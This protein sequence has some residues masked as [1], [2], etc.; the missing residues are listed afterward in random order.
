[1]LRGHEEAQ[2]HIRLHQG[3]AAQNFHSPSAAPYLTGSGEVF[4]DVCE[5][6]TR[7]G[8]DFFPDIAFEEPN[9]ECLTKKATAS[10]FF[11][12]LE[13]LYGVNSIEAATFEAAVFTYTKPQ[14]ITTL[15]MHAKMVCPFI[16]VNNRGRLY[17]NIA[18]LLDDRDQL[19]RLQKSCYEYA[20]ALHNGEYSVKQFLRLIE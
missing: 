9:D 10:I 7:S 19:E 1:M 17:D 15:S 2:K 12:R 4:L 11:D 20:R 13:Y 3:G 8:Y 16:I 14:T 5:D 6:L 18:L